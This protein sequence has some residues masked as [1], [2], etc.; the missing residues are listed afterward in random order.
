MIASQQTMLSNENRICNYLKL[1]LTKSDNDHLYRC[2]VINDAITRPITK[3]FSVLVEYKPEA[4][5][6]LLSAPET[7][8]KLA[9]LENTSIELYCNATG[10]PNV[11][12][13]Q[14]Y[15]NEIRL[16]DFT[17]LRSLKLAQLKRHQAGQYMCRAS[18]KHGMSAAT[19]HIEIIYAQLNALNRTTSDAESQNLREPK[20]I[21]I[22]SVENSSVTL[23][24]R[25]DSN[26]REEIVWYYYQLDR[27]DKVINK[28]K[29]NDF[30][31]IT[32]T[33]R[34][35]IQKTFS[36][37]MINKLSDRN[38]GYYACAVQFRLSDD[39]RGSY[40]V[41]ENVTYY[42]QVQCKSTFLYC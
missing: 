1:N 3:D 11:I 35:G 29:L 9:I 39:L 24:C 14:W 10:L 34:N 20:A 30:A 15:F 22:N 16:D 6:H 2:S 31:A 8:E 36:R 19:F 28:I 38:S 4:K 27:Q 12:S 13:Y 32:Q 21:Y 17:N 41:Q 5:L 37:F 40:L 25:L 33:G 23:N 26:R 7:D 42:L 18:N